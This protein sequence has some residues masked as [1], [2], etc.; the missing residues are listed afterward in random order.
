MMLN[1]G[2]SDPVHLLIVDPQNDFMDLPG[3]ALPVPG[4]RDDMRRLAAFIDRAA[5]RIAGITVTL[6]SHHSIGIERPGMWR[7][8]AGSAVAPFTPISAAQ[9]RA[10]SYL[11]RRLE[12]TSQV[13]AYLDA[14][15]AQGRYQLMVW[16]AH[17]EIGTWGHNVPDTLRAAYNHWEA[18]ALQPV[19]KIHKGMNPWTEHYSALK[20]E[21][22]D[23]GDPRTQ[24][25]T[26]LIAALD[27]AECLVIAGEASSHCVRATTDH[28]ADHLPSGRIG[29][30]VLF[31]DCMSPV[32]GF[33]AQAEAFLTG[34]RA[35]GA[36][37]TTS[38]EFR[39]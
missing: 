3:A 17:C 25:D 14:L 28:L 31:S 20:A 7:T 32:P 19:R 18:A 29:K 36:T 33:E 4:A 11:P 27:E 5:R 21:V 30:L 12:D 9:V 22:P 39:N 16:P 2:I 35:R 38:A 15:E 1:N 34:M 10:G 23:P 6:D 24:L 8:A 13:L 26:A 37:V